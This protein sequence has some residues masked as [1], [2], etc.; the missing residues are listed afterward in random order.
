MDRANVAPRGPGFHA[1]RNVH[2][3]R[4]VGATSA[5]CSRVPFLMLKPPVQRNAVVRS[6]VAI[7][8]GVLVV[9]LLGTM[10][11]AVVLHGAA[12]GP[13]P[14]P[15]EAMV[16]IMHALAAFA[17]GYVG[18]AIAHRRPATHGLAVGVLYLLATQFA[19]SLPVPLIPWPA[20]SPLWLTA[21]GMG[22]ALLGA[23]LGGT[24]RGQVEAET[25]TGR[26]AS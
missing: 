13:M 26:H 14:V 23:V 4:D 11:N 2:S 25:R 19:P 24:A 21:V 18:A 17:G 9:V 20:A 10:A 1:G 7:V 12:N 22:A 15:L 8:I 5:F 16:V 6:V 3:A